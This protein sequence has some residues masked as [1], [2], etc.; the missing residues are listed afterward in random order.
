VPDLGKAHA[1]ADRIFK[2]IDQPS[3]I[4]A[5]EMDKDTALIRIPVLKKLRARLN[6]KTS[7]LD[8]PQ[9]RKIGSSR[10]LTSPSIQTRPLLS[11]E[12]LD[13]AKVHLSVC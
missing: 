6:S 5:V 9:E 1:A 11:S 3:L 12:N 10:A 8:T 2:I 4:N 7:G 13:V